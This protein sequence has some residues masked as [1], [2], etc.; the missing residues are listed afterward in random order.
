MVNHY[1][2]TKAQF[3]NALITLMEQ[4]DLHTISVVRLSE[5]A[6]ISR[7]TFYLHY[8][9]MN[10]MI[11]CLEQEV[12]DMLKQIVY[13]NIDNLHDGKY[14]EPILELAN[15]IKENSAFIK[16]IT[17]KNGDPDFI[18]KIKKSLTRLSDYYAIRAIIEIPDNVVRE[19]YISFMISGGIGV[20]EDWITSNFTY[21]AD[22]MINSL[23]ALLSTNKKED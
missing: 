10:D 9:D 19:A 20:F 15:Y 23:I 11:C 13:R 1:I 2:T 14:F 5:C 22:S 7:G 8:K 6:H 18:V 16:V 3:K 21:S 4:Q 12:Y 17:S